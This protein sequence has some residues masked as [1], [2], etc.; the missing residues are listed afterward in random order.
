VYVSKAI[1]NV[2]TLPI[3]I[4]ISEKIREKIGQASHGSVTEREVRECFMAWDGVYA[5]DPREEHATQSGL[6]TKWF[7]GESHTGRLLKIM[8]VEDDED[9]YLKSAYPATAEVQHLFN[10]AVR[11]QGE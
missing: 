3:M 11:N 8:Y 4:V 10:E 2:Y 7:I 5:Y 9:V 6:P 1:K